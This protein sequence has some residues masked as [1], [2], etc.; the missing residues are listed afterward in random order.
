METIYLYHQEDYPASSYPEI[1]LALGYFDGVHRGHQEV[2]RTA[3]DIADIKGKA[4]GIMT[5]HP[6][7]KVVLSSKVT[8]E[9][10]R[11]ITPLPE[12]EE[13]LAKEQADYLFIVHFDKAFAALEP[14]QFIDQYVIDLHAVHVVAGFD[15]SYG[16]MG[17]GTMETLPFHSRKKFDQTTVGKVTDQD[18][19]ISSTLIKENILHGEISSANRLL[20]RPY[21]LTGVV[22]KGEQRGRTIG[23]PTANV[24]IN[25]PYI[26][27][28]VGVYAVQ[29]KVKGKWYDGVCN[30]GYKPTFHDEKSPVPEI[31]VHLFDFK[32]NIYGEAVEVWWIAYIRGEIKFSSAEELVDQI[33]RDKEKAIQIL[34]SI[35]A[36]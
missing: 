19:K 30:V 17:K 12:K 27:P 11:Y 35:P 25:E 16:R 32:D 7:P 14:Q 33:G 6:H 18:Q 28:G 29:L 3:R 13:Q 9:S 2:I 26:V 15:F 21:S 10:M 20:G 22:V 8:E 31:E 5:F 34:Q 1:V 36:P 24:Q 4:L 23:F